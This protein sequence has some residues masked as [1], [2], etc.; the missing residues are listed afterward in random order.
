MKQHASSGVN[1]T[2]QNNNNN[3]NN[4]HNDDDY[5]YDYC[6]D[7]KNDNYGVKHKYCWRPNDGVSRLFHDCY[8]NNIG[9]K[10]NNASSSQNQGGDNNQKQQQ[11]QQTKYNPI[12]LY[13]Q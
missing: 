13:K 2:N 8:D 7:D 10:K 3:N 12:T 9:I 4:N 1:E 11:Q 6:G 5:N